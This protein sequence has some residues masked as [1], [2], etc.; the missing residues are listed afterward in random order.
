MVRPSSEEVIGQMNLEVIKFIDFYLQNAHD[1]DDVTRKEKIQSWLDDF[2]PEF[3]TEERELIFD[4]VFDVIV[5]LGYDI[6][7]FDL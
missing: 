3:D 6:Y 5:L 1:I 7:D 2:Y 4:R